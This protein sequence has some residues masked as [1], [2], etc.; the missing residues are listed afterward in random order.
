MKWTLTHNV[1]EED[2]GKGGVV[3]I[4]GDDFARDHD[5]RDFISPDATLEHPAHR[6][7]AEH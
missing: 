1:K 4:F 2:T 3:W 6:M 5:N 7:T